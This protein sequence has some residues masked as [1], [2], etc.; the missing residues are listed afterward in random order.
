MFKTWDGL[1]CALK[2]GFA[3]I[4]ADLPVRT[5]LSLPMHKKKVMKRIGSA[6]SNRLYLVRA[7]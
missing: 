7:F 4:D 5:R 3:R 2:S 6:R 1:C